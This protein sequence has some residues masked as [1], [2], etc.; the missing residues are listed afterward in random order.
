MLCYALS[1]IYWPT[2]CLAIGKFLRHLSKINWHAD[3]YYPPC[4]KADALI[5]SVAMMHN[6]K[7]MH[8]SPITCFREKSLMHRSWWNMIKSHFC[9]QA[10]TIMLVLADDGCSV[11]RIVS[12]FVI[13][14][15]FHWQTAAFFVNRPFLCK[16]N[17]TYVMNNVWFT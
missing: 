12:M 6:K 7:Q 15:Y 16:T 14:D 3:P 9:R 5:S 13:H 4:K 10:R 17:C 11:N 1:Q 2:S 8:C